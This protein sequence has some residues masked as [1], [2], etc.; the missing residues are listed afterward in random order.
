LHREGLKAEEERALEEG[1]TRRCLVGGA[2]LLPALPV[3][4]AIPS[5]EPLRRNL[6]FAVWRGGTQIGRHSVRFDGGDAAFQV[7]IE[8]EML[9]KFGPI[10]VFNY[11]HEAQESWRDGR[12]TALRSRTTTNGREESV[13]ATRT[14]EGVAIVRED[15]RAPL[16]TAADAH[17]LTHW[18][19]AVLEGPL[20][21]PQTGALMREKVTRRPAE[22]VRLTDGR[23]VTGTRYALSGG[24]EI[25]DWYDDAATWVAL[26]G[27]APDGSII[28]Y[29]R[30]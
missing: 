25:T 21:N 3:F 4:A 29:R 20:F 5:P 30:V 12:F 10:P 18:N 13:S 9:V 6:N 17:P 11:H 2:L 14:D 24:V 28:E 26:R 15:G 22:A 8:A 23:T 7:A 1:L 27:K 16:K 19:A